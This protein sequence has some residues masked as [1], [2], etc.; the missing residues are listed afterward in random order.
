MIDDGVYPDMDC[1]IDGYGKLNADSKT[2]YNHIE[3]Y[4][5]ISFVAEGSTTSKYLTIAKL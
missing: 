3:N 1:R 5:L 2:H 4:D